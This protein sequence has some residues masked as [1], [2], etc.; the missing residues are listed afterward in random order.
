MSFVREGVQVWWCQ[1]SAIPHAQLDTTMRVSH[2]DQ[3][4]GEWRNLRHRVITHIDS[5]AVADQKFYRSAAV[6]ELPTDLALSI[7]PQ[8]LTL[9][10]NTPK[11][12]RITRNYSLIN[13]RYLL[14]SGALKAGGGIAQVG[15]DTDGR[16]IL[17]NCSVTERKIPGRYLTYQTVIRQSIY[18]RY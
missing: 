8:K 9:H 11:P 2:P 13:Q 4:L 3:L 14:F 1:N 12:Q 18:T 5:F 15:M 6:V 17:H 16:L 7:L 10:S